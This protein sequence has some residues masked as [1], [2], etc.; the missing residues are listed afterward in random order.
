MKITR[1]LLT[2]TLVLTIAMSLA[3]CEVIGSD[4]QGLIDEATAQLNQTIESLEATKT[5]LEG[6]K[7]TL[8]NAKAEL[9]NA[10]AALEGEKARL[11]GENAALE[12]RIERLL[13]CVE[14]D[15]D[16]EL[17]PNAD[18]THTEACLYCESS[19]TQNC[20]F[21]DYVDNGDGS[22]TATCPTCNNT[23][24]VDGSQLFVVVRT[25]DELREAASVDGTKIRLGADIDV[26][27]CIY[28]DDNTYVEIDMAGYSINCDDPSLN[29]FF[30]YGSLRIYD[31]VGGSS[32]TNGFNTYDG[33]YLKVGNI[34][35]K[36]EDPIGMEGTID[37]SEYRGGELKMYVE[38]FTDLIIPEGYV[39]VDEL[40]ENPTTDFSD[41]V[42]YGWII[43]TPPTE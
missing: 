32:I 30:V 22:F 25:E 20:T 21:L 6:A 11:E 16:M 10:K 4:V 42:D 27:D 41:A 1:I 23:N 17:T 24:T 37:L 34:K 2:L 9:E 19:T 5:E 39:I 33:T 36:R 40:Y 31:S 7:A 8:E 12:D 35:L 26:L 3:S 13:R 18:G 38:Y 28:V 29:E 15:H 14:G 43:L